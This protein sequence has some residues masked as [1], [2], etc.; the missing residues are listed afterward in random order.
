MRKTVIVVALAL[1]LAASGCGYHTSGN[2]SRL[3]QNVHTI[4][5]PA[6][7]NQTQTYRLEQV[8]TGAVVR[9]FVDRSKFRVTNEVSGEAD[10][11]LRGTVV[12]AQVAPLTYDSQT[13]RAS[14]AVI[15]LNMK[16]TLV[17][18]TGKP[19]YENSN[20]VFREQYQVSREISSFFSEENPAVDRMS[21]DF[22]RT[23]VSDIL[24][25]F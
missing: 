15:T 8:L 14:S 13:G 19:L 23:L 9:E 3:P 11:I 25:A 6:F 24:E 12:S 17:D 2:S 20:Y 7:I 22:A 1:V 21:R 18:R 16:V 4:A 10:A 5:I